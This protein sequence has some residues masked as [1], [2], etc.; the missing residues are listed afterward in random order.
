MSEIPI[1]SLEHICFSYPGGGRELFSD[2]NLSLARGE[3]LGLYGP[4]GNGKTTL[5]RLILGLEKPGR[6]RVL[7][8]GTPIRDEE[9][10]RALRR[11]VGLV[12]Q[13]AEDQLFCPTV[14]EDVAFGPLNL[15]LDPEEARERSLETIRLMGL[16]G[17]ENRLTHKLSGGEKKLV[18]LATVLSM[19]PEALLL[20]EPTSGLDPE[21]CARIVRILQNMDTARITV[22][23]DLDFLCA[24]SSFTMRLEA[25][26][27]VRDI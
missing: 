11:K 14:L 21:S 13:Q 17:F 20:D 2:L 3:R 8:H 18:S 15:G 24:V 5:L 27:L 6:G 22:S 16:D 7:A 19:R 12:F 25:G 23:H 10:W 9:G 4:N 26:G 1:F